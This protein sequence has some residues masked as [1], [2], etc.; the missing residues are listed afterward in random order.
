MF[1]EESVQHYLKSL[2]AFGFSFLSLNAQAEVQKSPAPC[3]ENENHNALD[4]ALGSWDIFVGDR[5]VAWIKLEKDGQNCVIRERYGVPGYEQ[6]GAGV[7]YWDPSSKIWRR[8]LVTSVGTV[9]TF[10]G[11]Q[12]GEK[13]VWNGREKR[14][15]GDIVLERVEMWRDRDVLYNNIFQSDDGGVTWR[16][17]GAEKRV[18][19]RRSEGE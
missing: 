12:S 9:E 8:I 19:H 18:P 13:F 10:E 15:N 4:F 11:F 2:M 7:D 16:Q 14:I 1:G 3:L 17:T 5:A 6:Y